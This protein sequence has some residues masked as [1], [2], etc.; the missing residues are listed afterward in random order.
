MGSMYS[1]GWMV[2]VG[3]LGAGLDADGGLDAWGSI[4]VRAS[5]F[6]VEAKGMREPATM[7]G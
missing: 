1:G 6:S 2:S 3:V 7:G 5:A 4:G